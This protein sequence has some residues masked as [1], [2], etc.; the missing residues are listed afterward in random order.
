MIAALISTLWIIPSTHFLKPLLF[1]NCSVYFINRAKKGPPTF[2]FTNVKRRLSLWLR[3]YVLVTTL[4]THIQMYG[5][6]NTKLHEFASMYWQL[7]YYLLLSPY[8]EYSCVLKNDLQSKMSVFLFPG[9][10][11]F[12]TCCHLRFKGI[13]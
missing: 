12:L 9:P 5:H 1:F 3:L 10:R 6:P 13:F 4:S 2:V 8:F 7:T 11:A